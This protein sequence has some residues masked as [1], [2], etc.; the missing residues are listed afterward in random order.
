M[1]KIILLATCLV[2]FLCTGQNLGQASEHKSTAPENLQ[3]TIEDAYIYAF[4]L[5][6]MDATKTTATNTETAISG[7][8]PVN[9]FM[10]GAGL[11][12]AKF[13][14]V[15]TPNVDTVYSQVWYDL[16]TEPMIYVLPTTNRFCQV[17]ILDAWTNTVA[18][19][20][21]G[22]TYAITQ[23]DW[24]GKLPEGINRVDVPTSMAWS[25]TRT[26]LLGEGDLPQ[27][28]DI[29]HQMKILPLSA[30][31][32]ETNYE[33]P[34]GSYNETN[35]Y[36]PVEKVLSMSPDAFFNKAND[37]MLHNP[38]AAIDKDILSRIAEINV[39]PGMKFDSSLLG[40]DGQANW[41]KMLQHIRPWL[42]EE[43]MNYSQKL[44]Q[45]NYFDAP[46]GDFGGEYNYRALVALA[47]LGA[48]TID[49]AIYP[50]TDVDIQGD[51]LTGTN[52]YILHF[53][54]YPPVLPG[55]FWSV[56]AY[57]ED[58]FLIDNPLNRYCINN[59]SR[60]K[61]NKDGSV[62]VILSKA[63]PEDTTNWLP[64]A[65]GRF[66]LYMRIYKPDM[67]AIPTWTAPEILKMQ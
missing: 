65:Q 33:A 52:S 57:G 66:H 59:R 14:D 50:K 9:Q 35:N 24:Q 31:I 48:N 10:H 42:V 22:G 28:H 5:V 61:G 58:D 43:G 27:V 32:A 19:L 54:T 46:I 36:V 18:V 38:P 44:G 30:Y 51:L 2:L 8:A 15:V 39:G 67:Q 11:V 63:A 20:E 53:D 45:W 56:T 16:S 13:K 25:I 23:S 55:G 3:Q 64:I 12:S 47:G 7:K 1:K 21:K 37:L 34:K 26:L 40:S 4:P 6:L 41:Q 60:L 29:Q 62:D 17:Q 49:V